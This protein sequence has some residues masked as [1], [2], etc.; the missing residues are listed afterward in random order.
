MDVVE[1]FRERRRMC[2][3]FGN[4]CHDCPANTESYCI[5][6]DGDEEAVPIVEKWSAE[7]PAKQDKVFFWSNI[8]RQTL[9][10][11]AE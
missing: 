7:H 10:A 9:T 4:G 6:F 1:F 3:F 5:A 11:L 2:T 8:R